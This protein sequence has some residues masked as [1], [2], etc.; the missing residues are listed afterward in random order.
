MSVRGSNTF[1]ANHPLFPLQLRIITL[2]RQE[3]MKPHQVKIED[4]VKSRRKMVSY[5]APDARRTKPEE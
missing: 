1:T 2:E 3:K 5:K 4:L